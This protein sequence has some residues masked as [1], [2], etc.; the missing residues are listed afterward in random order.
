MALPKENR[1]EKVV[2]VEQAIGKMSP[3]ELAALPGL[4]A[5]DFQVFGTGEHWKLI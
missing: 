4:D 2:A 3:Q 1:T 5:A